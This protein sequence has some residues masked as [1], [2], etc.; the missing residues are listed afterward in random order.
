[1]SEE[2]LQIILTVYRRTPN[3]SMPKAMSLAELRFA[4][5]QKKIR[6]LLDKLLACKKKSNRYKI[7]H[8]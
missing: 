3:P 8:R 1:M 6:S 7:Q 4:K 2:S 5:K